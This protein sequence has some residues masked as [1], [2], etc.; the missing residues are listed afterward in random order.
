[1]TLAA[2]II[3]L[4]GD[5]M[6]GLLAPPRQR[7]WRLASRSRAASILR[8]IAWLCAAAASAVPASGA[9]ADVCTDV[10][11]VIA[12][13]PNGIESIRGPSKS[14]DRWSATK[15]V[16][17]YRECY[18]LRNTKESPP[19]VGFYCT[20]P[21]VADE[22]VA[23][24][25]VANE[26]KKLA[27]CLAPA[28]KIFIQNVGTLALSSESAIVSLDVHPKFDLVPSS[29]SGASIQKS[30][31]ASLGVFATRSQSS[32]STSAFSAA[33]RPF[34][35]ATANSPEF[36]ATLKEVV[37]S[38]ASRFEAVRGAEA[39][40]NVWQSK[41]K[42]PGTDRCRIHHLDGLYY[43]TC[44]AGEYAEAEAAV[45]TA[46]GITKGVAACLGGDWGVRER[47]RRDSMSIYIEKTDLD[48]DVQLRVRGGDPWS[49]IIDVNAAEK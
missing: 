27:A 35:G 20:G 24:S 31:A 30:F 7:P 32:T 11:A 37:S 49:V 43:H 40:N 48:P 42:L 19:T 47:I 29:T 2:S 10:S 38:A 18:L 25:F 45:A 1:M 34:D 16:E 5:W 23:Q 3:K 26:G 17:G 9:A 15:S 14:S 28:F 33:L 4:G 22:A 41:L 46:R 39:R 8:G 36:C 13:M 12:A 21:N 6:T 44:L